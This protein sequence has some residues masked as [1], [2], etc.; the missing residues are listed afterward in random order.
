MFGTNIS[1]SPE[2]FGAG[3]RGVPYVYDESVERVHED[4]FRS[5]ALNRREL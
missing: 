2:V 5:P 4:V 3:E 1:W